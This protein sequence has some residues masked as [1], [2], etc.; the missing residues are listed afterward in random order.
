MKNKCLKAFSLVAALLAFNQ[1]FGACSNTGDPINITSSCEDLS[2]NNTVS[3]VTIA[4]GVTVSSFFATDAV[5]IG[6]PGNVTNTFLNLGTIS[7]G[8]YWNGLV[9]NGV[10]NTLQNQGAITS[11]SRSGLINSGNIGTLTNTGTINSGASGNSYGAIANNNQIGTLNNSGTI[12]ATVGIGG[13][14][15]YAIQQNGHIGTLN[16]SGTISA[17]NNAIYF[18]PA[19]S[20]RIDT[21]INSG[22]I[23]G[24]INGTGS[25]TFA[26]AIVLGAANSIG[27][28]INT[29]TIDHSVC[30]GGTCYAAIENNGGSI[31]T[32]TNLGN[33]TSGN[34]SN[35][36]YGIINSTTGTISTLNNLQSALTYSGNLPSNYNIII[37]STTSYGGLIASSL[38]TG[39]QTNFG[40]DITRSTLPTGVS[41]YSSVLNGLTSG[42]LLSTT[43]SFVGGLVTTS[44][45]LNN[46][47]GNTWNLQTTKTVAATPVVAG[48]AAGTNLAYVFAGQ[49]AN[50]SIQSNGVTIGA[51]VSGL[52]PAQ[53]NQLQN[54][55]AEGYSSN[56]TIGLEQMAHIT[57]TVMDRI[58][59]PMSASP[60][61][62]V[63]QDD[64]GRYLWADAAA[65]RGTVNNY[66]NL[67]GF[68]YSLYD[69]IIG[70]DIRRSKDGGFGVFAGTGTTSMT[71]SQQVTQNFN[72][73]NFYTGL[74]GARNFAEQVKLSGALGYMYGNTNANRSAPNVGDLVGG[75][76]TSSFKSNGVYAAAK[77]AKAYQAE[78]FTVSP[79]VGA[80][81]SQL[82]MGG[83]S[84]QGGNTFNYG[85]NSATAY[86]AVTFAGAD[87]IYPMLKGTNDPLSLI[88]FYKFGY[89]WYANSASAHTVTATT[90]FSG[91]T[92]SFAQVGANMGPVSNMVGLGIQGGITKDVSARIGAVASYNTYGHE[93]GGG[94]ELRLKF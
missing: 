9:N 30:S 22:T 20:S 44:W 34:T 85:I 38:T 24:G 45:I 53:V 71:E 50:T 12:S 75:N 54:V 13:N 66:N 11:S 52:A 72:T 74:Y 15:A 58:H 5:N 28:I 64:E 37:N 29:G 94:A 56:M 59:A 25:S 86:T 83:A 46:S 39:T 76:A 42:N 26:S 61:T 4:S 32:I 1:V 17:Q 41:N 73:T 33:L 82:W 27:T 23:Q 60:S 77:L 10:I 70:G 2:I 65:V 36:G 91:S 92:Q 31:G 51:A 55:H 48:S 69:I 8:I 7:N 49:S 88:G 68:G 19:F 90:S 93:Y 18:Q 43:G 35:S 78:N 80:S 16:N 87:F 81:Y 67:A 14:G 47:S 3:G 62:K 21:L 57:N 63:Y 6:T 84:E 89:D 40:I 79:F